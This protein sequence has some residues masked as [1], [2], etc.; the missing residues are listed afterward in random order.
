MEV[1]ESRVDTDVVSECGKKRNEVTL[2]IVLTKGNGVNTI[3]GDNDQPGLFGLTRV[4][5]QA[6]TINAFCF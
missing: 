6:N 1:K 3:T 4:A 2:L 5:S